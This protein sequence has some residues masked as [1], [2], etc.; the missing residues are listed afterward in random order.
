[1]RRTRNPVYRSSCDEGSN[2]SLSAN[3]MSAIV[4]ASPQKH[5]KRAFLLA[6]C[7]CACPL[8][9]AV[10]CHQ[11]IAKHG[12]VPWYE[13]MLTMTLT[14]KQIEQAKPKDKP[15]KLTDMPGLYL[16]VMPTGAKA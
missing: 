9:F 4:R 8:L 6:F 15:Y 1:M 13:V 3:L 11:P 5:S 2:P 10:L 7:V 16:H 12:N 14:A